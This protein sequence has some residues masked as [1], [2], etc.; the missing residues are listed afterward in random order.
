MGIGAAGRGQKAADVSAISLSRDYKEGAAAADAKYKGHTLSVGGKILYVG[1]DSLSPK[2]Y[3][4]VQLG[5][6]EG[7]N[8]NGVF[9]YF[10]PSTAW[11]TDGFKKGDAIVVRGVCEGE[12]LPGV[13]KLWDCSAP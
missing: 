1:T 5:E 9:C 7:R 8:F 3:V 6:E 12:L 2:D 10:P 4:C 11:Q 13:P